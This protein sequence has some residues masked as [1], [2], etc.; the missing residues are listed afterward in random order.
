MYGSDSIQ[1]IYYGRNPIKSGIFNN[2][3]LLETGS[4]FNNG[5]GPQP[6]TP[7][8]VSW[9]LITLPTTTEGYKSIAYGN[10]TYVATRSGNSNTFA[11]TTDDGNTWAEYT[12]T[13]N[14]QWDNIIY[15][16]QFI[17]CQRVN[18]SNITK[19]IDGTSW[20]EVDLTASGLTTVQ[21][22]AYGEGRYVAVANNKTAYST[23]S[24]NTWIG[25]TI[26]S[27][28]GDNNFTTNIAYGSSKFVA[29]NTS[30]SQAAYSSNGVTWFLVNLPIISST[31]KKIIYGDNKFIIIPRDGTTGAYSFDGVIWSA[32]VLPSNQDWGAVGYGNGVYTLL[33][34]YDSGSPAGNGVAG[35]STDGINWSV[36]DQLGGQYYVD[37]VY[38]NSKFIAVSEYGDNG[39]LGTILY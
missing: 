7:T 28:W 22:I 15:G 38:G 39:A 10:G 23:N 17:A 21:S 30:E 14:T 11:V 25:A 29:I 1:K 18:S 34:A 16:D 12:T 13:T 6:L 37:V 19:S 31:W 9:S 2:I 20:T 35:F 4:S 3:S 27:V 5:G 8:G 24:G 26:D 33:E 36:A 32:M